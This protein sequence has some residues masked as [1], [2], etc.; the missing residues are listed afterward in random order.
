MH[1]FLAWKWFC[2]LGESRQ[3]GTSAPDVVL[4]ALWHSYSTCSRYPDTPLTS[5]LFRGVQAE[6]GGHADW[7][8]R[9]ILLEQFCV[10]VCVH[11]RAHP[12]STTSMTCAEL[13]S[14]MFSANHFLVRFGWRLEYNQGCKILNDDDYGYYLCL[15]SLNFFSSMKLLDLCVCLCVWGKMSFG[16]I[17]GDRNI[18]TLVRNLQAG[19]F[20][21]A[22]IFLFDLGESH[23]S[24]FVL[25]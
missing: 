2:A 21:Q 3:L 4:W 24:M 10:C 14:W 20:L 18:L 23:R 7:T 16:R 15:K 17:K 1:K 5:G 6:V 22:D 8:L 12:C 13:V 9:R 11:A 19:I 25:R